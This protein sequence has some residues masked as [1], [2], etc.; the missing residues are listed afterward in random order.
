[1]TLKR[2]L[3]GVGFINAYDRS[4]IRGTFGVQPPEKFTEVAARELAVKQGVGVVVSGAIDNRGN[5]YDV[6]AKA[7]QTVTGNVIATAK[8]RASSRDQVLATMTTLTTAVRKGLGDN[9]SARDQMFA[10]TSLSAT[11]L[12]VVHQYAAAVEASSNNK[13]EQARQLFFRTVE[14]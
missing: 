2:G 9:T 1:Q 5:G 3:E 13:L 10:M 11:S 12:E 7:I 6:S 4:R 8:G 14:L